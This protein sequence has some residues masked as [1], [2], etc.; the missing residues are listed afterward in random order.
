LENDYSLSFI[1][2]T[3]N[4]G[5]KILSE[6]RTAMQDSINNENQE[7][8]FSWFTISYIPLFTDR[9]KQLNNKDIKVSFFSLNKVN[10]FIK[11]QK[12]PRSQSTI[13]Y[14]KSSVKIA[15]CRSEG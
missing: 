4:H 10:K 6:R 13:M 14:I 7:I 5:I 8:K 12:D 11:V 1:F 15:M 3:I 9:F 2:E